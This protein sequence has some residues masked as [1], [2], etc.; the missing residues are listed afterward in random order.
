MPTLAKT[1]MVGHANGRIVGSLYPNNRASKLMSNEIGGRYGKV[2]SSANSANHIPMAVQTQHKIEYKEVPSS[3]TI[4]TATVEVGAKSIPINVIFRSASSSLNVLQHH[5]G[6]NGDTQQSSSEDE[7][8]R[9]LHTVT[10]PIIQEIHE[11]ISPFRKI[12][13]EVHPVKEEIQTIVARKSESPHLS[14][15]N[16]DYKKELLNSAIMANNVESRSVGGSD[17]EKSL[18]KNVAYV[19]GSSTSGGDGGGILDSPNYKS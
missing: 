8:H 9:L 4:E 19:L 17:V 3:G 15:S 14:N 13:Q 6:A 7:P 10:K 1:A 11:I 5:Q 16:V 18:A 12:T 2:F